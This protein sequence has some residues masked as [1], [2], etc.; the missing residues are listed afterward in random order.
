MPS[1]KQVGLVPRTL[2]VCKSHVARQV[3]SNASQQQVYDLCSAAT[4]LAAFGVG[5]QKH[6]IF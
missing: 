1:P 5:Y 4:A 6:F 3:L 2:A